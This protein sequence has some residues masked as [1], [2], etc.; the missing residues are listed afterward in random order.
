LVAAAAPIDEIY[1]GRRL[2]F[3]FRLTTSR[4]VEMQ[5]TGYLHAAHL[6]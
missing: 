2:A 5:T 3:E 1:A 4:L 6:S